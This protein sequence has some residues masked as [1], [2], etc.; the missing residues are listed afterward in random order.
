MLRQASIFGAASILAL[1]ACGDSGDP[2]TSSGGAGQGGAT[3]STG[4][5]GQGGTAQGGA[6]Q[7]GSTTVGGGCAREAGPDDKPRFV[8]VGHPFDASKPDGTYGVLALSQAGVLTSTSTRFEM[9][10]AA[11]REMAFTPDGVL[12]FAAQ[13]DG[14]VGEFTIDAAGAV[15]VLDAGYSGDFYADAVRVSD[16]GSTLFIIDPDFP[17]SGGGIYSAPIFCDGTLGTATKMFATKSARAYVPLG[18]AAGAIVARGALE[19]TGISHAH[20]VSLAGPTLE[21]SVN[22][23]GDDDAIL[24]SFALTHDQK[25]LLIGDNSSF[26]GVPN[27]VGVV[28]VGASQLTTA[29]V[30]DDIEDP[31]ALATSPFDDAAIVLSGFG[32]AVFVLS[33]SPG[34]DPPFANEGE[35]AYVAGSP[36]VPGSL[37]M[38]GRGVATGRVFIGDVRGVYQV[39]FAGGGAVTD[40]GILDL[41]GGNE[42]IVAGIGVQP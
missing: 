25:Y 30:L 20:L 9:H 7:G 19:S 13:S 42:N 29:D 5:A 2:S 38:L 41:G 39:E 22:V 37:S 24:A 11:D 28:G 14:T 8:V 36:Q 35:L 27:R 15:T 17:E 12:G 6:G 26:S 10:E 1:I 4:G 31:Y 16:D 18:L 33:Y 40:L 32:D 21:S 3:T 34:A 23:F